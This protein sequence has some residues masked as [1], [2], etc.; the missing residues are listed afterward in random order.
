MSGISLSSIPLLK[1]WPL[2]SLCSSAFGISLWRM[3]RLKQTFAFYLSDLQSSAKSTENLS[4]KK[5]QISPALLLNSRGV[6]KGVNISTA[7]KITM[8]HW[9]SFLNDGIKH[10]TGLEGSRWHLNLPW[11]SILITLADCHSDIG[12]EASCISNW[13]QN[14]CQYLVPDLTPTEIRRNFVIY[15]WKLTIAFG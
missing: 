6:G 2:W 9:S 1:L 14:I 8:K 4:E 12:S 15:F 7:L 10:L 5:V 13:G 3:E 11:S